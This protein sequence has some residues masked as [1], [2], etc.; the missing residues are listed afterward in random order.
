[1]SDQENLV[2]YIPLFVETKHKWWKSE[3]AKHLKIDLTRRKGEKNNASTVPAQLL[4]QYPFSA[5]RGCMN[6]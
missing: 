6:L 3:R 2:L 1:M 4:M 5:N